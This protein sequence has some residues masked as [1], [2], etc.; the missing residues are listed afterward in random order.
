[1]NEQKKWMHCTKCTL[2]V[3]VLAITAAGEAIPEPHP[4]KDITVDIRCRL[5][6]DAPHRVPTLPDSF[7]V[8]VVVSTSST[9]ISSGSFEFPPQFK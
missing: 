2:M 4:C 5:P 3:G 8:Q 6:D 7:R 1:M 9:A